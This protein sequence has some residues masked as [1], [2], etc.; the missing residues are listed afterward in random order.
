MS[1]WR[2]FEEGTVPQWT[3]PEFYAGRDVAPHLHQEGHRDR[4]HLSA[5]MVKDAL[6]RGGGTD[7]VDLGGGDGGMLSLLPSHV[8]RWGYDLQ[9]TNVLA[10]KER[11]ELVEL[12]DVVAH[13][14]RVPQDEADVVVAT[15]FLEHLL[16]PHE[17]VRRVAQ[18]KARFLIASSPY[19]ETDKDHY[20]YHTYA[21]DVPGYMDLFEANGWH[22]IRH[23]TAWICQCVLAVKK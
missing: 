4:L 6:A 19:T 14:P 20:E 22:V 9:P 17:M 11:G 12:R 13:W 3:T 1:Q 15:E 18:T 16:D 21:W 8:S 10:A 23:E 7:V 5:V 2:L